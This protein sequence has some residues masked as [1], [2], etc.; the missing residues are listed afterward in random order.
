LGFL[1]KVTEVIYISEISVG[2][3]AY[4]EYMLAL[5]FHKY[6]RTRYTQKIIDITDYDW[7]C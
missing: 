7:G 5:N 4:F 2:A 3:T 6:R 1:N